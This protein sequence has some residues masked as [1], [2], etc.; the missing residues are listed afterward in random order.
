MV[1][2]CYHKMTH[3][4]SGSGFTNFPMSDSLTSVMR[5]LG[6]T[7]DLF[8]TY[9]L[10]L[11]AQESLDKWRRQSPEQHRQHANN[12][13]F[14]A[15]LEKVAGDNQVKLVKRK[16]RG[17]LQSGF[18]DIHTFVTSIGDRYDLGGCDVEKFSRDLLTC[19][20]E[21]SK[22][23]PLFEL[24]TGLQFLLQSVIESLVISDR[25]LY[26]RAQ[27]ELTECSVIEIFDPAISPRNKVIFA[28][29]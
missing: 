26:L 29:K 16:R 7:S 1:S 21:N 18:S 11:G 22:Y 10:R 25:A 20:D 24:V 23:F 6:V 12:V 27:C 4:G 8:N 19:H 13:A 2:C 9:M 5:R 17:V 3:C 15:V 14:R 28:S